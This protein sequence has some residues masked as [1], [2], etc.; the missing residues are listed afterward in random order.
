MKYINKVSFGAAPDDSF[1]FDLIN[2]EK[3]LANPANE[4]N[5]YQYD[6]KVI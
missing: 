6:S 1:P 2:G 4:S 3:I 5:N